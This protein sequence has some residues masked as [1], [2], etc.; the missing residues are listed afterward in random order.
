[1]LL[2][3]AAVV[4]VYSTVFALVIVSVG[5]GNLPANITGPFCLEYWSGFEE[6]VRKRTPSKESALQQVPIAKVFSFVTFPEPL[7]VLD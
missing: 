1:M 5:S 7:E 4:M 3:A 6:T 2:I